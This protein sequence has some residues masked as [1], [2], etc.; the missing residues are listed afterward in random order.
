MLRSVADYHD[1]SPLR[2]QDLSEQMDTP[3]VPLVTSTWDPIKMT[4]KQIV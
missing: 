1:L 2:E 3:P 4:K